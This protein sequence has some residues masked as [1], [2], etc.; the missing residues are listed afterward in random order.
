MKKGRTDRDWAVVAVMAFGAGA[1]FVW[2]LMSG[3]LR[4]VHA[5]KDLPAWVQAIGSIAA[6]LV[7]VGVPAWQRRQEL[8]DKRA[9]E[10]LVARSFGLILLRELETM[11]R[12]IERDIDEVEKRPL[13][14]DIMTN[15][16]TIP[17]EL[18]DKGESLHL[19][20]PAGGH[21]ISAIHAIHRARSACYGTGR[22]VYRENV[23]AFL[24]CMREAEHFCREAIAG[25]QASL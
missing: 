23:P 19:L 13:D 21:T 6:I 8:R 14:D 22:W 5:P 2:A 25:V 15:K 16:D 11:Q 1:F 12:R 18:W 3:G 9:Q 20:G 10:A 7:A 24:R 4:P 17:Q